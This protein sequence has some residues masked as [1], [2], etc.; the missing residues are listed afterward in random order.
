[1]FFSAKAGS[2][3]NEA[4]TILSIVTNKQKLRFSELTFGETESHIPYRTPLIYEVNLSG[5][6]CASIT[7]LV[8]CSDI[9]YVS[10]RMIWY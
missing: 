3:M 4:S 5:I 10:I 9:L 2:K 6:L 8:S 1:M 7:D